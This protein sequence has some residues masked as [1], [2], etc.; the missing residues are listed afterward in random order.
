MLRADFPTVI[1]KAIRKGNNIEE[2]ITINA[3]F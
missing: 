1:I 2:T 3:K